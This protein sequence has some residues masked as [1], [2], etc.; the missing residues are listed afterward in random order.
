MGDLG[1]PVVGTG[2]FHVSMERHPALPPATIDGM[3]FV[4]PATSLGAS[5]CVQIAVH[6]P[7]R[8]GQTMGTRGSFEWSAPPFHPPHLSGT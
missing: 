7:P 5:M 2:E 4:I 6:T 3:F 8:P 1:T